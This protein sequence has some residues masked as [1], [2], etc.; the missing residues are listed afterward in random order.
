MAKKLKA[1][2]KAAST[3]KNNLALLKAELAN[4]KQAALQ[5]ADALNRRGE[6]IQPYHYANASVEGKTNVVN[7][8]ELFSHVLTASK[9]GYTTELRNS[10]DGKYLQV[11]L[12]KRT[13]TPVPALFY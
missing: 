12:V 7:V 10:S 13:Y 6:E 8:Q 3:R 11:V 2:L 1:Q 4:V 5:F 9:L